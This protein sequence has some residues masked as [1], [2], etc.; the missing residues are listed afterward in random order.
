LDRVVPRELAPRSCTAAILILSESTATS[1]PIVAS[2]EIPG[3]MKVAPIL[4][5][6]WFP[7]AGAKRPIRWKPA[8]RAAVTRARAISSRPDDR[9]ER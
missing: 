5:R 1:V 9:G 3:F 6:F 4:V 2:S 8:K 7:W